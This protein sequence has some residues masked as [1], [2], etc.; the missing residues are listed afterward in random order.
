L[1]GQEVVRLKTEVDNLEALVG[2]GR[3][4]EAVRVVQVQA[5]SV[6]ITGKKL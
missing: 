3:E 1:Q 2:V 6:A 5:L 4:T